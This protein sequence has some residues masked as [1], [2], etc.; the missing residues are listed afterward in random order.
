MLVVMF[1]FTAKSVHN[2]ARALGVI[3]RCGGNRPHC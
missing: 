2:Q 1:L 3:L